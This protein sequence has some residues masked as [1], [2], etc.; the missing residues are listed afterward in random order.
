MLKPLKFRTIFKD[1]IWG[2][3]KIKTILNKDFSPLPNC[4]ETWEISGVEG[5]VSVVAEGEYAGKSLVE[6]IDKYTDKL[7]GKKLYKKF[8]DQFPLLIKFID[9]NDD[10]SIQVHPDDK[11]ARKRHNSFGKTEMWYVIQADPG[12]KLNAGFNRKVD[13]ETY[14]HH[15]QNNTLE[16]ILNFEEVRA[17]DV[18]FLP[19]GRVHYIG[20]GICLA[21]IQQTSDITY[22]IYDFDRRDDK[23]NLRELHTDLALDAIDFNFYENYKTRY[24]PKKNEIINLV[25]C[26]YFNT[27]VLN[28]DTVV[29]RNY[30]DVDSFVVIICLEGALKIK[31]D[32]FAIHVKQGDSIL[33]PAEIKSLTFEPDGE[34]KILESF[35]P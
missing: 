15:L 22:R 17:G 13:K 12:A 2:G 28:Y 20:K 8:H 9:A 26:Q 18:F 25:T 14:L 16:E 23:G 3:N 5:N 35:V 31:G 6:L 32:K 30:A 11:L 27:S 34:F 24:T 29:S 4:G 33:V 19:A 1:K 21:E 7:I 10:L